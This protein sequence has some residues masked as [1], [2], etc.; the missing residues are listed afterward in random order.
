M[1][2]LNI[3]LKCIINQILKINII[4]HLTSFN[5]LMYRKQHNVSDATL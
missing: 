5:T 4:F 3:E 1:K 2:I